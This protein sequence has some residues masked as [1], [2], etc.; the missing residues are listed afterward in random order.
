VTLEGARGNIAEKGFLK[1]ERSPL[2]FLPQES[3]TVSAGRQ[4]HRII[5]RRL[6]ARLRPSCLGLGDCWRCPGGRGRMVAIARPVI[7]LSHQPTGI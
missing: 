7:G 6:Q 4:A 2:H 5:I 1:G 3:P